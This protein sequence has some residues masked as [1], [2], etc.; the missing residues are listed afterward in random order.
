[1][2]GGTPSSPHLPPHHRQV[3]LESGTHTLSGEIGVL[4]D[5]TGTTGVTIPDGTIPETV[6]GVGETPTTDP[7]HVVSL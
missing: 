5:G 1:M 3:V 4:N 7:S 6:I 2:H